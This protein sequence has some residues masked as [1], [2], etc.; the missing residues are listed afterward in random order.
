MNTVK[1]TPQRAN[2]DHVQHSD[3]IIIGAGPAGLAFARYF[4]SS[5]LRITLLERA[6]FDSIANPAYDGREI[7]LTHRSKEILQNLGAWQRFT[8]N[9]IY[10]LHEAKVYNGDFNYALHF[11]VPRDMQVLTSIDRLGNLVSNHN[12]RQALF[13]EVKTLPNVTMINDVTVDQVKTDSC[14]ARVILKSGEVYDARLLVGADS[15]MS[16]VRRELGIGSMMNDFGRTVIVFRVTHECS[17]Q[18]VAQECFLY[19]RT[20]ALLPLTD[21]MTN[22]V[23]TLDN[24][25]AESLL[26]MNDEALAL[27][28]QRMMGDRLGKLTLAGTVHHYPLMGVHAKTFVST[29]AALIGDAAVGMHPVTAHGFNLGL[30]SADTLARLIHKAYAKGEDIGNARLLRHYDHSH[31]LHTRP[32]YH[33]TNAMVGLF[34]NDTRPAQVVRDLALRISNHMPPVKRWIA[35][36][37]TGK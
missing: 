27:E 32:L 37:L 3:I 5:P 20:L 8:P 14:S 26:S 13:D 36:Q 33:G 25:Q 7:A 12:I 17:N 15:R 21:T 6:P 1:P 24:T 4:K 31:Q 10:K 28:V 29:R 35:G 34:T 23:I 16:F 2:G 18:A 30:M 11:K 22:C 19:G 9:E